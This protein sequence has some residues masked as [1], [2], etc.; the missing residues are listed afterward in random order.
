MMRQGVSAE[1][2]QMQSYVVY[3]M[4]IDSHQEIRYPHSFSLCIFKALREEYLH[5]K[6]LGNST[7]IVFLIVPFI[8]D[9]I[10]PKTK[11]KII[12][13]RKL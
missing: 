7:P 11:L 3:L 9:T 1:A 5:W 6:F 8:P 13:H 2:I 10:I 4:W 12:E